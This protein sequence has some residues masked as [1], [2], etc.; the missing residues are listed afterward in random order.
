[1]SSATAGSRERRRIARCLGTGGCEAISSIR[2]P[3]H[4]PI[5]KRTGSGS[6]IEF[7]SVVEAV[8][9]A[10]EAQ[11]GLIE[12][13]AG[14]PPEGRIS[15]RSPD[16]IPAFTREMIKLFALTCGRPHPG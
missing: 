6:L 15:S 10:I 11:N 2:P 5:A 3:H 9:C 16:D 8:R 1:M 7:R 14:L 4:G 12:C 13:N